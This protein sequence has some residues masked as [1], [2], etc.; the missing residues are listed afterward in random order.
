MS[1]NYIGALCAMGALIFAMAGLIGLSLLPLAVGL[2]VVVR[3]RHG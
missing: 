3:A 1:P 2:V